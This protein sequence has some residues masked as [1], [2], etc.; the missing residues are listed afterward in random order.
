MEIAHLQNRYDALDEQLQ[1]LQVGNAWRETARVALAAVAPAHPV[2]DGVVR[3]AAVLLVAFLLLAIAAAVVASK[4]DPR[5]YVAS[6]IEQ[7]L[8]FAP[9]AQLAD[10]DDVSRNTFEEQLMQLAVAV[11]NALKRSGL[12]SCV[13]TGTGPGTGVSTVA[14]RV[15]TRLESVNR[16]AVLVDALG[17]R[18]AVWPAGQDHEAAESSETRPLIQIKQLADEAR[19]KNGTVVLADAA[20]LTVSAETEYLACHMDGVIVVIESGVTTR[21]ELRATAGVLRQLDVGAVG[22]VLNRVRLAKADGGF[23]RSMR[24]MENHVRRQRHRREPEEVRTRRVSAEPVLVP[25]TAPEPAPEVEER[26]AHSEEPVAPQP[27][28]A[29]AA[30]PSAPQTPSAPAAQ[31]KREPDLSWWAADPLLHPNRPTRSPDKWW[32]EAAPAAG[33]EVSAQESRFS[34]LRKLF[35][36]KAAGTA[37]EMAKPSSAEASAPMAENT[38]KPPL[39]GIEF[40]AQASTAVRREAA[41]KSVPVGG[42]RAT[43]EITTVPE[44][45]PPRETRDVSRDDEAAGRRDRRDTWD[46]VAVLPSWRGQYRRKE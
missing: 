3:N 18:P 46:G 35:A 43:S 11:E 26:R 34:S 10:T 17:V 6:D 22:Y 21:A 13:F 32:S 7:A 15:R 27:A 14:G 2:L 9:L 29:V 39:K 1:N 24:A 20:P 38:A 40:G 16:P 31:E 12:K 37:N 4:I 23:R 41:A 33:R 36:D 28:A 42:R 19:V 45:L 8:G 25:Q 30:E 5:I 44:I